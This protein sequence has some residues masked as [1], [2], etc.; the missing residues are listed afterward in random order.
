[1]VIVIEFHSLLH[2]LYKV[3]LNEGCLYICFIMYGIPSVDLLH[4]LIFLSFT[5]MMLSMEVL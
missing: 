3:D 1:M 5:K 2:F 4:K